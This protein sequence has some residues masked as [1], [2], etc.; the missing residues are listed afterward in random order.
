MRLTLKRYQTGES[1]QSTDLNIA[2]NVEKD[3][4]K[5]PFSIRELLD[6][7]SYELRA[8]TFYML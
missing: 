3:S 2:Q 8:L 6:G 4:K 5:E 1:S 7:F